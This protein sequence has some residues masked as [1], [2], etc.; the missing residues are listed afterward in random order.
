V[1]KEKIASTLDE[2]LIIEL[3]NLVNKQV[4]QSR[5]QAIQEAVKEKLLRM[6]RT[7]LTEEC[8]KLE[9][10]CEKEMAEEGLAEDIKER[11]AY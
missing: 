11:P 5:S 2:K 1:G 7:R 8:A 6:K 3:D 9:P 4:F 10:P